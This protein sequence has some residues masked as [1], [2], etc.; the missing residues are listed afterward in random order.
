MAEIG[1][2]QLVLWT[3]IGLVVALFIAIRMLVNMDLGRD[4][5]LYSQF[6]ADA[7]FKRD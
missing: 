3:S 2:Y 5:Q 6:N 1:Y 4:P 7:E